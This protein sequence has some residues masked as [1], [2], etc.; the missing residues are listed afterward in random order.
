MSNSLSIA[1]NIYGFTRVKTA[2]KATGSYTHPLFVRGNPDACSFMV[3]VKVKKKGIRK[4][5][6]HSGGKSNR[7]DP[8]K[9]SHS[10]DKFTRSNKNA[11]SPLLQDRPKSPTKKLMI[12]PT[13]LRSVSPSSLNES[14]M[15]N[16]NIEPTPIRYGSTTARNTSSMAMHT[17]LIP[18]ENRQVSVQVHPMKLLSLRTAGMVP[19]SYDPQEQ[20]QHYSRQPIRKL[21]NN[22]ELDLDTI[23]DD[24]GGSN[25]CN[26]R[27]ADN[28]VFDHN[29]HMVEESFF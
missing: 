12:E 1:V 7:C 28:I 2:G 11:L 6:N 4:S 3:R 13:P 20:K 26:P 24:D 22:V 21:Y 17:N 27:A 14:S 8:I 9:R 18:C 5:L 10:F 19:L 15:S 16:D 23:F 25:R 29:F